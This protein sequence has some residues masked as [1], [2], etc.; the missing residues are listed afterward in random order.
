MGRI[1]FRPSNDRPPVTSVPKTS[2]LGTYSEL[3]KRGG[4]RT[5]CHDKEKKEAEMEREKRRRSKMKKGYSV[6]PLRSAIWYEL[7]NL[8]ASTSRPSYQVC[9]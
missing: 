1:N 4:K 2:V 6:L 3:K 9:S 8:C 5:K 7:A